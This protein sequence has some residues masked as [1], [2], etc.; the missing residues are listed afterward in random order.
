MEEK[1]MFNL[2]KLKLVKDLFDNNELDVMAPVDWKSD[3]HQMGI[4][5][6]NRKDYYPSVII[7]RG[8][9][10]ELI[11]YKKAIY[12]N[13]VPNG[14]GEIMFWSFDLHSIPFQPKWVTS[15]LQ[16]TTEFNNH[17]L[18]DKLVWYIPLIYGTNITNKLIN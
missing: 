12:L 8:K 13:A 6:K 2:I 7:E 14:N 18:K 9:Y 16:S 10:L 3:K 1:D 11:K 5:Y 15:T 4:E 17:K